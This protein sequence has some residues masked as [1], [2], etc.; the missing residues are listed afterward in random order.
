MPTLGGFEH[1]RFILGAITSLF[2]PSLIYENVARG[3]CA[4][5]AAV[6]IDAG[7]AVLYGPFHDGI[8]RLNVDFMRRAI[9]LDI[10]NVRHSGTPGGEDR[11]D[12][13]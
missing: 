3:A 13:V 4:G 11:P 9:E 8:A 12:M 1:F 2:P 7:N 5:A 10:G 6:G